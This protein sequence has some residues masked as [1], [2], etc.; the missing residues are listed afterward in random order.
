M[1]ANI[2][3][4]VKLFHYITYIMNNLYKHI[5]LF[6]TQDYLIDDFI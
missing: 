3:K 2:I 5:L 1:Y 6:I 4:Y